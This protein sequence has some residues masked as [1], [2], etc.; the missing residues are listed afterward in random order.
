MWAVSCSVWGCR[1][2]L[3]C[4]A[5]C[6]HCQPCSASRRTVSGPAVL[7]LSCRRT[8]TRQVPGMEKQISF[9]FLGTDV[10]YQILFIL[11]E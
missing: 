8:K 2:D 7:N 9:F 1:G 10:P 4:V 11:H 5:L 6:K 3:S